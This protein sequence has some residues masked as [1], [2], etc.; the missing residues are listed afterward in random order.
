MRLKQYFMVA[1]LLLSHAGV[2][3]AAS[4]FIASDEWESYVHKDG[5]GY[6]L[7]LMKEIFEAEG[8]EVSFK[9]FPYKRTVEMVSTNKAD[10][11]LGAYQKEA[12]TGTFAKYPLEIDKVDAAVNPEIAK[13]WSGI[14]SLAGKRVGAVKGYAFDDYMDVKM[15]YKELTQLK[16]M[17]K[18]L[19][20]GR[21]DAVIDYEADIRVAEKEVNEAPQYTIINSV[22]E[23]PS[24][25]VFANTENG[26]KMLA[27][28]ER[29]ME[30][31]M[32]NGR[33]KEIMQNNVGSL[34]SYPGE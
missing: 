17:L 30:R 18:M 15:R 24:Y 2:V 29:G 10:V 20:H 12:V 7:E 32:A 8:V 33:L 11:M 16:S 28:F 4:L 23:N 31:L 21:L 26:K 5:T 3:A 6:Y 25:A 22:I 34:A 13:N 19:N 14:Q 9:I 27:I 1:I